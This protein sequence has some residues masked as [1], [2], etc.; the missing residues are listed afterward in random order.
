MLWSRILGVAIL[1]LMGFFVYRGR[2]TSGDD[3][4]HTST[5]DRSEHPVQFW[6]SIA[7]GVA[8]GL[9]LLIGLIHF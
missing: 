2:V 9:V 6:F 7:V 3:F 1:G 8:A 5:I 4:G